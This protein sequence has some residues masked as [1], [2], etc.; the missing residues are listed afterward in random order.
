MRW[1]KL[2]VED[3]KF[4]HAVA[5]ERY[6]INT[7]TSL[8]TTRGRIA[9]D[10][11]EKAAILWDSYRARMS[12]T[13]DPEMLFN[14]QDLVKTHENLGWLADPFTR[15]EIDRIIK[16]MPNDKAPRPD[17]F[18]GLFLKKCWHIIK[19]DIYA[20]C[21]DFYNGNL[22]IQSINSCLITL[23]PKINNPMGVN[24][25]KPISLLNSVLKLLTKILAKRLQM[26]IIPLIHK[27]QYG[28]IRSRTIKIV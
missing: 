25:F 3:T 8:E 27:N 10:H 19:D 21:E 18:N 6:R 12:K 28:F 22:D 16:R 4:F 1:V 23:V 2:G 7:I 11:S 5:T 17:G 20:L 15:E 24:D 14:L 13:E 26:V 9:L